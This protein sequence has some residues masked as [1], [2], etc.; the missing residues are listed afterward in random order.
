MG[1]GDVG[2][3]AFRGKFPTIAKIPF[4]SD[5]KFI[6]TMQD[7]ETPQGNKRLVFV[8][9]AWDEI[10]RRCGTQAANGDAFTSEPINTSFWT[11]E[12]STF[13]ANG[14]RVLAVAQM[15]VPADKT[16]LTVEEIRDA[17]LSSP[18]LQL[19]CLL[20]ILDPCRESAARAIEMC[21]TAGINVKMITGDHADTACYIAKQLGIIDAP[22][23]DRYLRVKDTDP[24]ARKHIVLRGEEV[25]SGTLPP[26]RVSLLL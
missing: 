21:H 23:F 24:V 8:K 10:I 18:A 4:D 9:G 5:Y 7:V 26:L 17:C 22:T 12:A 11:S 15:E 14:M 20:A 13:A 19:N 3:T 16:N 1:G 25:C 6:A 2:I